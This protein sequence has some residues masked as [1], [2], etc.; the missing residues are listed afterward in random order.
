MVKFRVLRFTVFII[1]DSVLEFH[2]FD[3]LGQPVR[4]VEPAPCSLSA[5]GQMKT[6]AEAVSLER[7][8][9][10]LAVHNPTVATVDSMGLVVRICTQ[11]SAG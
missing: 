10:V 11:C 7:H 5:Q 4:S 8:P 9:R 2:T 1:L 6:M 3:H